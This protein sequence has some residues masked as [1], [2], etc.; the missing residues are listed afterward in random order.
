MKVSNY[1]QETVNLAIGQ[2][3]THVADDGVLIAATIIRFADGLL[4]L[5]FSDGDQ[6][7][8]LPSSCY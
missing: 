2:T 5:S 7:I 6:G 4:V 3:V 8:E 1:H